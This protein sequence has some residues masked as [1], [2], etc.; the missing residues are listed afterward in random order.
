MVKSETIHIRVDPKLKEESERILSELGVN[1]SYAV[2]M[3]L[4]QVVI[5][6]GFPFEIALPRSEQK[7]EK[8]AVLINLTAGEEASPKTKRIIR[9]YLR[10]DIDYETA[11]FAIKRNLIK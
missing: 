11:V 8:L 2:A 1:T 6:Q 7:K 9:L 3:F 5:Q 4:K 10:G